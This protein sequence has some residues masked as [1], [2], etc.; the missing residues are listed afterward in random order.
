MTERELPSSVLPEHG[1]TVITSIL[2]MQMLVI[3]MAFC[4]TTSSRRH[5]PPPMPKG[6]PARLTRWAV[7]GFGAPIVRLV[8]TLR[9][10]RI[11]QQKMRRLRK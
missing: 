3:F 7:L 11:P 4:L 2:E 9:Q 10:R 1:K 6:S 5:R 8:E